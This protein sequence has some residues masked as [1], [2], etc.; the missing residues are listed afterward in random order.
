M[1]DKKIYQPLTNINEVTSILS[2]IAIFG[3]LTEEQLSIVFKILK[4]TTYEK[5]G[6]VFK[7]GDPPSYIYII[8]SGK[9]KLFLEEESG[10]L[11]LIEFGVGDCFGESSLIGIQAHAVSAIATEKTTLIVLS[12]KALYSL[13]ETNPRI[14][15]LILL[16]IAREISRR[17]SQADDVLLHYVIGKK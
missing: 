15:A 16:N 9:I 4:K 7:Q 1:G 5:D 3:G 10:G 14:Y 2:K 11:E 6:L 17:L 12:G 13:Y 8:E